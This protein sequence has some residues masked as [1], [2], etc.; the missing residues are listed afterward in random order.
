MGSF[1]PMVCSMTLGPANPIRALGSAR[2]TSPSIAKLAVTPPVVGSVSTLI[3]R[4]PAS[5]C[6]FKAAEVF[7]ICIRET[8][9]SCI[10][11]PP[12]HAKRITGSPSLVA[13]STARAIFSPTASPMLAMRKRPSQTPNTTSV[14]SIL[15]LPVTMASLSPVFSRS[16]LS[17]SSYPLYSSGFGVSRPSSHSSKVPSSATISIRRYACT[18]KYPPHL[19]QI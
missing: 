10:L 11:A 8:I 18:R 3:Y 9:P 4:S 7:A 19:G 16:P 15:A 12:E 5:L 1:W 14:P 2:I 6:R 17:F 13:R